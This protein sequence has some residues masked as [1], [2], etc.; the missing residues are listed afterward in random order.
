[1][2]HEIDVAPDIL[3]LHEDVMCVIS[4]VARTEE[5]DVCS[6]VP[7]KRPRLLL[8]FDVVPLA[9][10]RQACWSV[11]YNLMCKARSGERRLGGM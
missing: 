9:K 3:Q 5:P 4:E 1:M 7:T 8:M 6:E 11:S 10:D 2:Q